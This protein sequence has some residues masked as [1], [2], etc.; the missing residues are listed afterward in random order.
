MSL[1]KLTEKI[2]KLAVEKYMYKEFSST[3][4]EIPKEA[5]NEIYLNLFK[6][7]IVGSSKRLYEVVFGESGRKP[8]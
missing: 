3:V 7:V 1:E 8:K 6:P 5:I 4:P 2:I